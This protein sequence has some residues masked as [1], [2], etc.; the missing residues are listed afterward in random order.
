MN[1]HFTSDTHFF[2]ANIIKYCSRPFSGV[3]QMHS[4]MVGRWNSVVAPDDVIIHVGDLTAGLSNRRE[5]LKGL[6]RSL[7][8]TKVLI[9][10][11]HD[12]LPNE[13]YLTS[14]IT[15]VYDSANFGG[16]LLV[17]YPL[18]DALARGIDPTPWG[19]I[20]HVVHGHVHSVNTPEFEN[21]F[22][23]A[24]DR[25]GYTPVGLTIAVPQGLQESFLSAFTSALATSQ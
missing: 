1:V 12:H 5:E 24:S 8:G 22:N 15:R 25:H 16:V 6:I 19:S 18:H 21:H 14:G 4:E 20:E 10:G 23:V 13:W 7:N 9:R 17:H 11:N 2:H 3:E